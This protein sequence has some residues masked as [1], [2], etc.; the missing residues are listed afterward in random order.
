[1]EGCGGVS[2]A[3]GGGQVGPLGEGGGRE[4]AVAGPAEEAARRAAGG[5][6]GREVEAGTAAVTM[7]AR[8]AEPVAADQRREGRQPGVCLV[9]P[10]VLELGRE[11][12]E[13]QA[14]GLRRE[15]AR[16]RELERLPRDGQRDRH[17]VAGQVD[18][19]SELA[20]GRDEGRPEET[21][22][23][24]RGAGKTEDCRGQDE[25][26]GLNGARGGT[27]R[28]TRTG[29]TGHEVSMPEQGTEK[30]GKGEQ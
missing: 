23:A 8:T 5:Q 28:D 13:G 9:R 26:N 3:R 4:Q 7:S 16:R 30:E 15:P 19:E 12:V 27:G 11:E 17:A 18:R 1:M 22:G 25:R 24:G 10:F 20:G 29:R 21:G 14:D 6:G 2:G